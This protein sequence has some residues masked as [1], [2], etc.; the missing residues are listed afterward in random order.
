MT[1]A[2]DGI[3]L[4]DGKAD[5][6]PTDASS[7]V[8]VQALKPDPNTPA[9]DGEI[10]IGL[11][12]SIEPRMLFQSVEKVTIR[13]AVDD[14][15]QE[16]AQ[17]TTD[18]APAGAAPGAAPARAG[19]AVIMPFPG[20]GVALGAGDVQQDAV[21]HLKKGEKASKSLS[22]LSGTISAHILTEAAPVITADDI[23]KVKAGAVFKGGENGVLTIADV[24]KNPA[25]QVVIRLE[26]QPPTD[27]VPVGGANPAP[28][29]RPIRIRPVPLPA[30]PGGGVAPPVMAGGMA[31]AIVIGPGGWNAQGAAGLDL[32]DDKGNV[33]KQ[34]GSQIQ[35]QIT[36]VNGVGTATQTYTL[37]FQP[38]KDQEPSKLV[39]MG[40]K[41]L[42]VDV[43]FTLKDV[44]LP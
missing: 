19:R 15:K 14:Q 16:L 9:P 40:R 37:T 1:A 29:R 24:A 26:L 32:L 13:K 4:T 8:R 28:I 12:L 41:V 35:N 31:A 18:A 30:P 38:E 43:P 3:T 25:G 23:M 36:V 20:A 21:V 7:A 39:Y 42:S 33:V 10:L 11:R 44:P 22:E 5:S 34:V 27:S 6:L 2:P 17:T